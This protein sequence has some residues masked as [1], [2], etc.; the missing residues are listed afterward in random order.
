MEASLDSMIAKVVASIEERD[1][2]NDARWKALLDKAG[3]K[4]KF[5][6]VKV[7]VGKV[8]AHATLQTSHESVASRGD[9]D[10][11]GSKIL[12]VD[13]SMMDDDTKAWCKMVWARIMQEM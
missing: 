4:I 3:Q 12:T 10:E 8:A 9:Q 5:E 7:K 13:T 11:R 6:K 2:M 1:D